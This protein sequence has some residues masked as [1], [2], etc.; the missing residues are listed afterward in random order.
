MVKIYKHILVIEGWGKT[1]IDIITPLMQAL[2]I[3]F[4]VTLG[5]FISY[6]LMRREIK[7]TVKS[8]LTSKQAQ[9]FGEVFARTKQIL[10]DEKLGEEIADILK[11]VRI[12]LKEL[13]LKE[14]PQTELIKLPEGETNG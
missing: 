5:S 2:V 6:Y 9:D 8:I 7:K 14:N 13:T 4:G 3:A 11:G 1:T 10:N 12:A